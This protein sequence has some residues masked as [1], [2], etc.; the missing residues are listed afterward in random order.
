MFREFFVP[1]GAGARR[2]HQFFDDLLAPGLVAL[3]RAP[4]ISAPAPRSCGCWMVS[5]IPS[6]CPEPIE[7]CAECRASPI[8]TMFLKDQRSFQIHGKLR[9]TDLFDTSGCPSRV[10]ANT[11]SQMACDCS[12][13]LSAKP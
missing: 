4:K 13:V 3:E 12:I 10:A 7:K 5:P 6:R 11:C 1:V 9:H 2:R 8:S